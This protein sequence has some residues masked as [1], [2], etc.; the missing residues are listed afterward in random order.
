MTSRKLLLSA[1]IAG[2][3]WMPSKATAQTIVNQPV[4]FTFSGPVSLPGITLQAGKYQFKL[5][6]S[7][8]DRQIVQIFDESGKS[9]GMATTIP[10]WRAN[11]EPV[12]EK[13]EVNFLE[14]PEGMPQAVRIW[15]YP[16]I[17]TGGHEF[18]YP[19]AQ[20]EQ[21]AKVSKTG[22]LTTTGNDVSSGKMVRLSSS[23]ETDLTSDASGAANHPADTT[24]M[25]NANASAMAPAESPAA[26]VT[27]PAPAAS[28]NS[29]ADLQA[30]AATRPAPAR[31][32]LPKTASNMPT[33]ATIGFLA[34]VAGFALIG[35][36]RIA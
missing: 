30:N 1:A 11:G 22:V 19:R 35:R 23:G 13:P 25:N 10:A 32:A 21:I 18:V 27:A 7:N 36:R 12:P 5:A 8:V 20:A 6:S 3:L 17:R 2:L 28:S 34:L 9:V 15:W 4:Y 29:K 14:T 24:A 31:R 33:V 16:G 26:P